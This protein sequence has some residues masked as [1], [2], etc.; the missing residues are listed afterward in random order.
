MCNQYISNK[1]ADT[2]MWWI[3]VVALIAIIVFILILL[4]FR[5]GLDKIKGTVEGN[6]DSLGDIDKDKVPNFQD[7][8]PCTAALIQSKLLP[9]C[10]KDTTEEQAL[11]DQE[12]FSSRNCQKEETSSSN[13]SSSVPEIKLQLSDETGKKITVSGYETISSKIYYE[14]SCD[15]CIVYITG[16][17]SGT[18]NPGS[19]IYSLPDKG[20][21]TFTLTEKGKEIEQHTIIKK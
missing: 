6:I 10:K 12:L 21:Y 9:G 3:I 5:G 8:C 4:F 20:E 13:P 16:I 15:N 2:H 14:F 18:L 19:G 11:K 1:K 17:K 7:K